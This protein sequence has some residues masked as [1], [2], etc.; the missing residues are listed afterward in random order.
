MIEGYLTRN[1]VIIVGYLWV[2]SLVACCG[3]VYDLLHKERNVKRNALGTI[4]AALGVG[5]LWPVTLFFMLLERFGTLK[6]AAESI[7]GMG[8][9]A[10]FFAILISIGLAIW[11]WIF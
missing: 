10:W 11:H 6:F 2:P 8:M 5:V 3:T 9:I 7:L 4:L 1:D